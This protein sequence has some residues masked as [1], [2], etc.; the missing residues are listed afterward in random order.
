LSDVPRQWA[1]PVTCSE[2]FR[3]RADFVADCASRKLEPRF[4]PHSHVGIPRASRTAASALPI[5]RAG[6]RKGPLMLPVLGRTPVIPRSRVQRVAAPTERRAR[7]PRSAR[8]AVLSDFGAEARPLRYE[9]APSPA[10]AVAAGGHSRNSARSR[11]YSSR[12]PLVSRRRACRRE[13]G[14]E[15]VASGSRVLRARAASAA[16]RRPGAAAWRRARRRR[17][18]IGRRAPR[19][20]R[21]NRRW[22]RVGCVLHSL[23]FSCVPSP[24]SPSAV[25]L[26]LLPLLNLPASF[27][28]VAFYGPAPA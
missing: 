14:A 18:R 20:I 21:T 3:L 2:R 23:P 28:A 22:G 8:P 15:Q 25:C 11:A 5:L 24:Q 26:Q 1:G 19:A 13:R 12:S 9:R 16:S 4:L 7:I 27:L 17:P 6:R 10:F